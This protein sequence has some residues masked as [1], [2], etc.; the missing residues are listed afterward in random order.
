MIK[1]FKEDLNMAV[2]T[3]KYVLDKRSPILCIFHYKEDGAWQFS[4]DEKNLVNDDFRVISLREMINIDDSVL[5][6]A[7]LSSGYL[8]Y[9][10]SVDQTWQIS[11][12]V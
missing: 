8:V 3:T 9:R 4:G 5:E 11:K 12:I 7:D 6:V 10:P 1:T 2:F